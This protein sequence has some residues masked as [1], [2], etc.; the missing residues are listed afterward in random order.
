MLLNVDS[1]AEFE[2]CVFLATVIFSVGYLQH[3]PEA[4]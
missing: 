4:A 2:G 1:A 3:V